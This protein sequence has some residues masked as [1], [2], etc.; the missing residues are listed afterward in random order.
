MGENIYMLPSDVNLNIRSGTVRYNNKILV[1]NGKFSLGKNDKVNA[2]FPNALKPEEQQQK[3]DSKVV[4][5]PTTI[6]KDSNVVTQKP[7]TPTKRKKCLHT[8]F[9]CSI[10]DMVHV[11]MKKGTAVPFIGSDKNWIR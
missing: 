2:G 4:Q 3:K 7:I 8:F 9:N 11:M 5:N 10:Y 1:S 6:H